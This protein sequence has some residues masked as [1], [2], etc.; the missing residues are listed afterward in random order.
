MNR[1]NALML[2][3]VVM[4]SAGVVALVQAQNTRIA[5]LNARPAA[6]TYVIPHILEKSGTISNTQ[7]TFDTNIFMTY[8][9]GLAGTRPGT[10]ATVELYLFD[11]SSSTPLMNNGQAVCNPCS[12][13]L[14]TT[15]R[16][17][18]IRIDDLI[19]VKGNFDKS[20]KLGYGVIVVGGQD[21]DG[22]N[23]QGFVVNAHSNPFD[24]S[25]SGFEPQPIT[26]A[27]Q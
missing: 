2:V 21:P 11:Q 13:P 24:L 10:G 3:S 1:P 7:F 6:R 20:V 23:L 19:T 12:F 22:V 14:D 17:R 25:I 8:T 9:P 26:A 27:A 15:N 4:L 16:F 5:R 18:S